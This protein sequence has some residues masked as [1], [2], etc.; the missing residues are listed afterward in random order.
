MTPSP[1]ADPLPAVTVPP[2]LTA[3]WVRDDAYLAAAVQLA[4][5]DR[6]AWLRFAAPLWMAVAIALI[7]SPF[8]LLG[9]ILGRGLPAGN[10]P[11]LLLCALLLVI[12]AANT[13][14]A[15]LRA[16]ARRYAF[17][18]DTARWEFTAE[19]ARYRVTTPD[20]Q[21]RH[22]ARSRWSWFSAVT[23][24]STGLR[25]HRKGSAEGYFIAAAA[26][27]AGAQG[28]A[29]QVQQAVVAHAQ[30]AGLPVRRPPLGD[31]AGMAGALLALAML[32]VVTLSVTAVVAAWPQVR[33]GYWLTLCASAVDTFWWAGAL[34]APVVLALHLALAWCLHHRQP[35]RELPAQAPHLVLALLWGALLLAGLEA[36][37]TLIFDDALAQSRFAVPSVAACAGVFVLLSA[38]VLHRCAITPWVVRRAALH[39]GRSTRLESP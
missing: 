15:M 19:E 21:L 26:W 36:L 29:S 18:G 1:A 11:T 23:A 10:V 28:D 8:G 25:L 3:Q 38:F 9:A 33:H 12:A 31:W 17:A 35:G 20:G 16:N 6:P 5:I 2:V 7:F 13:H 24:D 22:E 39:N 37:R 27:G 4:F 30:S 32:L 14:H 34:L